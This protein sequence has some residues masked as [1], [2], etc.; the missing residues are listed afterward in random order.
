MIAA[1]LMAETLARV[2]LWPGLGLI[3]VLEMATLRDELSGVLNRRG[4]WRAAERLDNRTILLFDIDHFKRINDTFGH[5]TGDTV[6]RR[7]TTLAGSVLGANTIFGRIGGEEFAAALTEMT[8]MHARRVAE[9]LRTAFEQVEGPDS[10]T[11]SVGISLPNEASLSLND[12]M[13]LADRALY[14]AKRLGR[15]RTVVHVDDC[16]KMVGMPEA[17]ATRTRRSLRD[18]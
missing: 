11:V 9:R 4:F 7:F 13:A 10:A 6:I 3:M 1:M 12:Q 14:R 5:A 18:L 8:P 2:V 17:G 15:N 16:A